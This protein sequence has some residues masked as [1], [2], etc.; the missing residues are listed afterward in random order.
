MNFFEALSQHGLGQIHANAIERRFLNRTDSLVGSRH[1]QV[2]ARHM[3][4]KEFASPV[5]YRC[6][7]WLESECDDVGVVQTFRIR[8]QLDGTLDFFQ[9]PARDDNL[10][11]R[12]ID[13]FR[14]FPEL[15]L[16]KN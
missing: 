8:Y 14:L 6:V 4:M 1:K 10:T 9:C 16:L 2:L 13:A 5:G 11:E 7:R 12:P 15:S 3:S